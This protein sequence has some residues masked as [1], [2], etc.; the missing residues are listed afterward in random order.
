M[1]ANLLTRIILISLVI[2][3][4]NDFVANT[5]DFFGNEWVRVINLSQPKQHR[6]QQQQKTNRILCKVIINNQ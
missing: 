1:N 6:L 5:S 2:H 4:Y 3:T